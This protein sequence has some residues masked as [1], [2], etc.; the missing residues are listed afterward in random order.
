[1]RRG[2]K[3]NDLRPQRNRPVVAI[4]GRVMKT[5]KDRHDATGHLR[6]QRRTCL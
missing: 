4:A 5:D 3:P 6:V 1:V 2:A